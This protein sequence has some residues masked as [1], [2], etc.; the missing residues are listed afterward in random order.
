MLHYVYLV[1]YAVDVAVVI[2]KGTSEVVLPRLNQV[3]IR[4]SMW[5]ENCRLEL[6]VTKTEIV[7][8][9]QHGIRQ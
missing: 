5:V 9:T 1:R 4:V 7:M 3:M 8:L 2:K 6:V